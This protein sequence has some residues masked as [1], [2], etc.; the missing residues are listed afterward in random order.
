[1]MSRPSNDIYWLTEADLREIGEYPPEI[2]EFLI[3]KCGYN[4]NAVFNPRSSAERVGALN[5]SVCT[6][7][8]LSEAHRTSIARLR[9]GW[10]P[11]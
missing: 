8:I 9:Q 10:R 3:Q 7:G 4:R 6:S 5:A 2:E 11:Y 1:M